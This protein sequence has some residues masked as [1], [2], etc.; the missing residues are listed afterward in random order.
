MNTIKLT[1]TTSSTPSESK[2]S[3]RSIRQV[4]ISLLS[5]VF[6]AGALP[7]CTTDQMNAIN[8]AMVQAT[9]A[10]GQI[11]QAQQEHAAQEW[12]H[13]NPIAGISHG[14][15]GGLQVGES[16]GHGIV[17]KPARPNSN[18]VSELD[19]S[20]AQPNFRLPTLNLPTVRIP[21]PRLPEVH[22]PR[23]KLPE[24]RIPT[25]KLPPVKV[26]KPRLPSVKLPF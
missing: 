12:A 10:A 5:G 14:K 15:P 3:R 8:N 25:P 26:P 2:S 22:I 6:V 18:R 21:S 20:H 19:H 24:V 4:A 7:S 23:P 11:H 17:Q 9:Q 16:M 1:A 13:N